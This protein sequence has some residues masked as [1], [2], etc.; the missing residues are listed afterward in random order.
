[1]FQAKVADVFSVNQFV[2]LNFG[3]DFGLRGNLKV[4]RINLISG[5]PHLFTTVLDCMVVKKHVSL[6]L[7]L[8]ILAVTTVVSMF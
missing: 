8:L 7:F 6:I 5:L 3:P 1:M 4:K 2:S